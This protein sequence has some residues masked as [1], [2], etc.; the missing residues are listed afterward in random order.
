MKLKTKI[1]L[2]PVLSLILFVQIAGAWEQT[3]GGENYDL[4]YSVQETDD[5]GFIMTGMSNSF[6]EEW[7]DYNGYVVK[8]DIDGV[9]EWSFDFGDEGFEIFRGVVVAEDGGYLL[10]GFTN[11]YG[12]GEN[13][14]WVVKVDDEGTETWSETYGTTGVENCSSVLSTPDGG[15]LLVGS[16]SPF[17]GQ[18]IAGL[19]VKI[20]SEGNEEWVQTYGGEGDE[21]LDKAAV[22]DDGYIIAGTIKELGSQDYDCYILKTDFDGNEDWHTTWG[23]GNDEALET[24]VVLADGGYCFAGYQNEGETV[25]N[26]GLLLKLDE[27]GDEVW[28]VLSGEGDHQAFNAL[29]YTGSGFIAAGETY[30]N[31]NSYDV[32]VVHFDDSGSEQSS[33]S[34]G[35]IGVDGAYDIIATSDGGYAITGTTSS[36]GAGD[37]DFYLLGFPG[38]GNSINSSEFSSIPSEFYIESIYPNPFNSSTF[39]NISLVNSTPLELFIYDSLGRQVSHIKNKLY[40]P[41][42]NRIPFTNTGLSSGNY[43][44]QAVSKGKEQDVKRVVF[45]K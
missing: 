3:Y 1:S 9:E 25:E 15:Y 12:A 5:G 28:S 30:S 13:D 23:E 17:V 18:T 35:G 45:L 44:I 16:Y 33:D 38:E 14:C 8:T 24:V 10:A 29:L 26:D 42:L 32:Y 31:E 6:T 27:N 20:D 37:Q 41:G 22:T 34:T 11:S 40:R 43:Y 2:V 21:Y 19:L 4:A 7:L 36:I 39:I